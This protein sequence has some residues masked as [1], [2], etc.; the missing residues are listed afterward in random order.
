MPVSYLNPNIESSK[1][2]ILVMNDFYPR[3]IVNPDQL[4]SGKPGSFALI[5]R[6]ENASLYEIT[7]K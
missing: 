3:I 6:F 5:K 7:G 4:S 2:I 1:R